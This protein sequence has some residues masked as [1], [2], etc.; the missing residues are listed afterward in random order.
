MQQRVRSSLLSFPLQA[1]QLSFE[2]GAVDI[3][4]GASNVRYFALASGIDAPALSLS[5]FERQPEAF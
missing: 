3:N 4:L 2:N 5:Q 1:T